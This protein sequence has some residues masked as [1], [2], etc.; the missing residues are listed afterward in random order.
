AASDG[1]A[2]LL[3]YCSRLACPITADVRSTRRVVSVS[4]GVMRYSPRNGR[5]GAV[6]RAFGS[7]MA[8]F[9]AAGGN[10]TMAA[11]VMHAAA[12]ALS[13]E[14]HRPRLP[15]LDVRRLWLHLRRSRRPAA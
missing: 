7:L 4:S 14:R 1:V 9:P 8:R 15:H 5:G 2:C 3:R 11:R 6:A 13:D 10:G 12:S